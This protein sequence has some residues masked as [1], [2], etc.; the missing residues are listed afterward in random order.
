MS[1]ADG[2]VGRDDRA[3]SDLVGFIL[4]FALVVSVVAIISVTGLSTLESAR[5][6][7]QTNNAERAF[8][9]L[10]DNVDDVV[11][12]GAP[13]RATEISLDDATVRLGDPIQ[14]EVRDP[15]ASDPTFLE[16]RTFKPR[17]VIY[18]AGGTQLVYV[19]GA[20]FRVE[21][22]GGVVLEP[23]H[24]VLERDRTFLPVV[25][26]AS[27]TGSGQSVQASTVLVRALANSRRLK[28]ANES[29][30]FDNVWINVTS[31]RRDL[32]QDMLESHSELSCSAT[33]PETVKCQLGYVPN[34]IYVVDYRLALDLET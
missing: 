28:V 24:P 32:W 3:V 33:G 34:R 21:R 26:T 1:R 31:P 7:E 10:S 17:P 14:V 15:N 20:V 2:S 16:N 29:G 25:N 19:M 5:D 6:T 18:D 4:V 8:E 13:S 22:G 27:A 30:Q 11:E 9:V 12:R 23:W